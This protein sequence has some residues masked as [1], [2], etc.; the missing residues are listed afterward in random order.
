MNFKKLGAILLVFSFVLVSFTAC[1]SVKRPDTRQGFI[2]LVKKRKYFTASKEFS[3]NKSLNQIV[4]K[5]SKQSKKCLN[6]EVQY[7]YRRSKI[8][9]FTR[10]YSYGLARPT[11]N[12]LEYTIYMNGKPTFAMDYI[13]IRKNKSKAIMYYPRN[14]KSINKSV[15]NWSHG[16]SSAC[17]ELI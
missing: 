2:E 14:F 16:T 13:K 10:A 3:V 17:P 8:T 9:A 5:L 15:E 6:K 12:K 1:I 11:K 4:N 7:K